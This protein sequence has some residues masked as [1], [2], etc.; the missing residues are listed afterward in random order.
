MAKDGS[1]SSGRGRATSRGDRQCVAL[2]RSCHEHPQA[3]RCRKGRRIDH[4]VRRKKVRSCSSFDPWR[5]CNVTRPQV[6][7]RTRVAVR[8][9]TQSLLPLNRFRVEAAVRTPL[10][11]LCPDFSLGG[12]GR[13]GKAEYSGA[14]C[15]TAEASSAT[16]HADSWCRRSTREERSLRG[17]AKN[18]SS[19][20]QKETG[21][22]PSRDSP[23]KEAGV[24]R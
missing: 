21:F 24:S 8:L 14:A 4:A 10:P 7:A 1:A 11:N 22:R 16:E 9:C 12:D 6:P 18:L 15:Q 13:S 2:Q 5:M 3:R 17:L 23:R 20:L 19:R